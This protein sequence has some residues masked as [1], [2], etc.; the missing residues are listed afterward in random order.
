MIA[1][2]ASDLHLVVGRPPLFRL[3]GDLAETKAPVLPPESSRALIHSLL[4][5]AQK[6]AIEQ[7]LDLDFAYQLSDGA[8]RF[9]A[10]ILWQHRGL[11]AV[12]RL[13]PSKI[14]TMEQLG[15]PP[16]AKRIAE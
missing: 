2:G 9:R 16:V 3:R 10:N 15:L 12:L 4:S 6:E 8:A 7:N 5:A 1:V 14:L 11:G 13:I